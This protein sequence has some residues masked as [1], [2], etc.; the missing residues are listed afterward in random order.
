MRR[1]TVLILPPQLVFPGWVVGLLLSVPF[2]LAMYFQAKLKP[3]L[4]TPL[5]EHTTKY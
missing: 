2:S 3:T 5:L 1:S 4:V